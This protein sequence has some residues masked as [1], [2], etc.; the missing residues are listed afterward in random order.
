MSQA[1]KQLIINFFFQKYS[2]IDIIK[3]QENHLANEIL[4]KVLEASEDTFTVH[5]DDLMK[6]RTTQHE[7]HKKFLVITIASPKDLLLDFEKSFNT[8]SFNRNAFFLIVL[9][10]NESADESAMI[11]KWFWK[12]SFYNVNILTESSSNIE[13]LTFFPFSDGKCGKPTVQSV[14]V[15]DKISLKWKIIFTFRKS[16]K[17]CTIADLFTLQQSLEL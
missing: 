3:G 11:F 6:M 7:G 4:S 2:N 12:K 5:I 10:N 15:F 17:P 8:M 13:M 16:L 9:H 14:N 1:I